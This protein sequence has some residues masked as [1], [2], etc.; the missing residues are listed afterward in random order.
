MKNE[1]LCPCFS[2]KAYAV[3]CKPLHEGAWPENALQ[4]MRSRFSA[5]ALNLPTYIIATTHPSSPLYETDLPAWKRKITAFSKNT[6]F[7]NLEILSFEENEMTA[8]VTFTAYLSQGAHDATFTEK[9]HFEKLSGRWLY[10][11]AR[12]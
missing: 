12:P 9:S 3:C 5:Y 4:L 10:H 7:L 11:S 2:G 6:S 8:T 1:D